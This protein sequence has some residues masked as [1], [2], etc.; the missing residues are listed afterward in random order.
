MIR[1]GGVRLPVGRPSSYTDEIGARVC[2]VYGSAVGTLRA[3][4]EADPS[5]PDLST[6]YDWEQRHP[7]FAE[8]LSRAR[9]RRAHLMALEA[10]EI[11]DA[12]QCDTITKV[13]RNGEEYEVADHEWINRS[14]LRV[15][16]RL[17]LAKAL[18]QRVY[19]DKNETSGTVEVVHRIHVGPKPE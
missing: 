4:F 19:G 7:Q 2:E 10:V 18:N 13:G 9:Q 14:R 1:H 3:S 17:R 12:G 15:E 8:Q 6:I 5:L 16:T 11:A